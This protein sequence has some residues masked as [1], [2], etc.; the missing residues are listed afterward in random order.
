MNGLLKITR[1]A[2]EVSRTN[3]IMPSK[4]GTIQVPSDIFLVFVI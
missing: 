2:V 1:F 3:F 4:F